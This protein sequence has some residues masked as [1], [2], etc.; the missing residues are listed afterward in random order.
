ML[1]SITPNEATQI[2][3]TI[4]MFEVI[5]KS[6][7]TDCEALEILRE[8]YFK[9]GRDQ[10]VIGISR[11][12][13]QAYVS[14]GEISSAIL[15]F[16]SI[17]R[18]CPGDAEAQSALKQIESKATQLTEPPSPGLPPPDAIPETKPSTASRVTTTQWDVPPPKTVE[19]ND[20]R[21]EMR[22]I[23]VDGKQLS[24][25]D[26]DLYWVTP[27][28]NEENLV[29]PFLQ[30][31][32]EKQLLPAETSLKILCEKTRLGFVPL[33]KYDIDIELARGYPREICLRWCVLPF[34]HLSK[35]LM[36]ATTNPF[37]E[38]ASRELDRFQTQTGNRLRLLWYLVP[39][40]DLIK[41]L[42]KTFR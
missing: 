32:A 30:R 42:R 1:P 34:D 24:A 40:A 37:N 35:T 10:D 15:E 7:P 21:Q 39:P 4:E 20:G 31:I 8:A 22:K 41:A 38:Q 14:H 33:D 9:L 17:L 29:E 11:R 2:L 6:D 12:M 27:S 28:A 16:E 36:V 3:Q 18:R 5:V 19:L 13:A 23:F 25:S 26:F